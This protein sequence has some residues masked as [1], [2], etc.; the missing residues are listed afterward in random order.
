MDP[1]E[2][3]QLNTYCQHIGLEFMFINDVEQCQWIRQKFETPG[4]M[5]FTNEEKRTL[6]ARLVRSM[7]FE[8]FLARKWS[9]EKRF[10]L[11]GC[12]VMIPA[13]KTIIDKSSEMGIEYVIMG[14]PH[15]GRLNVL[16]N[17]IRK[18]LEQIFC[19]FDPKLEAADEN[20]ALYLLPLIDAASRFVAQLS[21][22]D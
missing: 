3:M 14:M 19:Q 15:R 12:E 16:A 9:S 7:R 20:M 17:V 8:D 4:V 2:V 21:Y 10:G 5:K 13:L 11:E 6:L 1:D 22:P 18:E